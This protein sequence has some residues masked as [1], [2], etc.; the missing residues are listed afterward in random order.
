MVVYWVSRYIFCCSNGMLVLYWQSN[1][2]NQL[3]KQFHETGVLCYLR[4]FVFVSSCFG[5]TLLLRQLM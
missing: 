4:D 5:G 3:V 1:L 2:E